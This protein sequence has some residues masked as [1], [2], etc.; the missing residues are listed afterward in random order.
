VAWSADAFARPLLNLGSGLAIAIVL[1]AALLR[2]L[3]KG[4]VWDRLVVQ[5]ASSGTAQVGGGAAE[6]ASGLAALVGRRGVAVT[7]LRP[8]GQVEVDGHRYEAKVEVGAI[9]RGAAVVVTGCSDFAL[10]VEG[11]DA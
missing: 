7:A 9:D 6:A 10:T 8:G 3:P 1:F 5:S 2:Y 11:V 4:W